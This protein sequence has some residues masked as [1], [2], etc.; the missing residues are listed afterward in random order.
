M[1][2]LIIGGG[3]REHAPNLAN[4]YIINKQYNEAKQLIK[5][6]E[7]RMQ[8]NSKFISTDPRV[9]KLKALLKLGVDR[10]KRRNYVINS[11]FKA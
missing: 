1:N 3:G 8:Q 4:I 2:I 7:D 9:D 5:Q 11:A 10:L 6:T